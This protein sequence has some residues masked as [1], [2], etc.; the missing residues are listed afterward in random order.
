MVPPPP[1]PGEGEDAVRASL[2]ERRE[3]VKGRRETMVRVRVG[4]WVKGEENKNGVE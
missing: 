1:P 4:G 3:R 2:V